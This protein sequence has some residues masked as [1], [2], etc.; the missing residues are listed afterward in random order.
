MCVSYIIR[1]IITHDY[2]AFHDSCPK[3]ALIKKNACNYLIKRLND[4]LI[5]RKYFLVL[6]KM[7]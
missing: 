5:A 6:D 3:L 1:L 2:S 4:N 7:A